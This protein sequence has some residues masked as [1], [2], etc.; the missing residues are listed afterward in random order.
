MG[1]PH[2]GVARKSVNVFKNWFP[3]LSWA[4]TYN[5]S[6]TTTTTTMTTTC[7]PQHTHTLMLPCCGILSKA[8]S[9][10]FGYY[11]V[12]EPWANSFTLWDLSFFLCKLGSWWGHFLVTR[13][14]C[15]SRLCPGR[16]ALRR[17]HYRCHPRW[18]LSTSALMTPGEASGIGRNDRWSQIL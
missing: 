13:R 10:Q 6:G 3:H 4:T 15:K 17:G 9:S 1:E 12:T 11:F 8:I 18:H 14:V 16:F 2:L 5:C 7:P